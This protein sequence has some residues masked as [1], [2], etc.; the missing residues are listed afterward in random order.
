M[1]LVQLAQRIRSARTDRQLTLEQLAE[2]TG[3]TKSALSKFENFRVTP[4]LGALGQ[5]RRGA[6]RDH[7]G[8][9]RRRG[10]EAEAWWWCERRNAC[11]SSATGRASRIRYNALAHKRRDK[12]MEPFL[13]EV[14]TGVARSRRLAHEGEEFIMVL[15]GSIDYE[16]GDERL[17]LDVGRLH[18]CGRFGRAHPQQPRTTT[19]PRCWWSGCPA[20]RAATAPT[21]AARFATGRSP[22]CGVASQDSTWRR[23]ITVAATALPRRRISCTRNLEP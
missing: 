8:A 18:V 14:P 6:G 22:A 17:R 1:N 4:S 16:Y 19:P 5:H 2:R 21:A 23:R 3:L 13:L 20:A 10:R 7:V 12:V 11:R 15:S 9:A